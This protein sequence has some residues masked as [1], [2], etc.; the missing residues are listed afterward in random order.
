MASEARQLACTYLNAEARSCYWYR[1]LTELSGLMRYAPGKVEGGQQYMQDYI[2]LSD[3]I[4]ELVQE[5]VLAK[6]ALDR[7]AP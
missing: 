5:H 3:F 4:Q 1:L 2:P 7:W 6:E